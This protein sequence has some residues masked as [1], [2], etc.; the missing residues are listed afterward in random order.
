MKT[1]FIAL[2]SVVVALV[3]ALTCSYVLMVKAYDYAEQ[4]SNE[5]AKQIKHEIMVPP[6]ND[7]L[8]TILS[9]G[10]GITEWILRTTTVGVTPNAAFAVDLTATQ[11]TDS[12]TQEILIQDTHATQNL[13]VKPIAW[14]GVTTCNALCIASGYTCSVASTDGWRLTAGQAMEFRFDGTNCVCVVGSGAGTNYQSVR[15]IR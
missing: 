2:A 4:K 11:Q 8:F 3:V 6:T 12:F 9:K 7:K 10:L 1:F 5:I 14:S 15:A 13:C